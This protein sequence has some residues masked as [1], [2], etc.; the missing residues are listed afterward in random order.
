M[1]GFAQSQ[2]SV[3]G[4]GIVGLFI[5]GIESGLVIAQFSQWFATLDGSESS[6]LS[7]VI[8]FVTVVGLAQS[9]IAFASVW[10]KYVLQFG[11]FP[12]EGWGDYIQLIPTMAISVPVQALMIRRCYYLVSENMFI[13]TPLVLLVVASVVVSLW[14][15]VLVF[16]EAASDVALITS[17]DPVRLQKLAGISWP[18]LMSILL[19]AV[20][21]L[22][23]TGILL[24]YLT[25]TAKRVYAIHKRR[26]AMAIWLSVIQAMTGKLYVLSLFYMINAQPLKPNEPTTV[27]STFTVPMEVM[28][29]RTLDTRGEDI[30]LSDIV[31]ERGPARSIGFAV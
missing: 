6:I 10:S 1:S 11:M 20:L 4:P 27:I 30:A 15:T 14:S 25:R 18:Y 5:Q 21:D 31:V 12:H 8:V 17:G 22:T 2:A 13:I 16:R 29:A 23:L 26:I 19:P 24:Y 7:T 9:G 3:L 28:H